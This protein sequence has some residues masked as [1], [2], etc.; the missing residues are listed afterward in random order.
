[1]DEEVYDNLHETM[2]I[3]S[4]LLNTETSVH[5]R[6]RELERPDTGISE[7]ILDLLADPRAGGYYQLD[8]EEYGAGILSFTLG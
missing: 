2:N 7:D 4:A 6:I 5:V 8:V 3:A 1:L